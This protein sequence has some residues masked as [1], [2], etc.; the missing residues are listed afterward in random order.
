MLVIKLKTLHMLSVHS[1]TEWLH[2]SM[3]FFLSINSIPSGVYT[4]FSLLSCQW[5]P[6]LFFISWL[7]WIVLQWRTSLT[8]H[9]CPDQFPWGLFWSHHPDTLWGILLPTIRRTYCMYW[10]SPLSI[11][12]GLGIILLSQVVNKMQTLCMYAVLFEIKFRS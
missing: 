10:L 6:R 11:P 7:L 5:T 9:S 8:A 2:Q 4:T 3:I 1:S 12:Q